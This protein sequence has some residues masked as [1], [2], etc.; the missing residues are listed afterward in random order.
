[1]AS[2]RLQDPADE[3]F[4]VPTDNG[5]ANSCVSGE[6]QEPL[7]FRLRRGLIQTPNE[8]EVLWGHISQEGD[9]NS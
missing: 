8:L 4:A 6:S 7:H 5:D 1:M 9:H 2:P 3:L